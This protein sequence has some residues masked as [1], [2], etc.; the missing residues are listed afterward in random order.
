MEKKAT[1]SLR[2]D[3]VTQEQL[4][5]IAQKAYK[6][7]ARYYYSGLSTSYLIRKCIEYCS[8]ID[9]DNQEIF[10]KLFGSCNPKS[11]E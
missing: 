1:I 9:L 5:Y 4:D 6:H 3:E 11:F 2:I 7:L 8:N 10:M